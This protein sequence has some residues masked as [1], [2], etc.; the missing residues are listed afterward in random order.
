MLH[1]LQILEQY[2]GHSGFRPNQQKIIEAILENEDCLALLPTGGGKSVCFQIPA[3]IKEGICIVVSPLIALM[4]DQVA[5]LNQKGIKAM[6][7]T[8][9]NHYSELERM[10]DNCVFGN[11]KFLYIS[12]ERLEN[13]L[14][15]DR[16]KS[17]KVSLIAVDEA[18]CIS[19]WGHDFRPAYRN[20]KTLRA[21][22]PHTAVIA[23]TATATKHV[24]KDVTEKLGFLGPKVF[25]SSFFRPN[26]SYHSMS[27]KD[28]QNK[29]ISLLKKVKSS[30]I[31]YV[32][33]RI[34]TEQLATTLELQGISSGFY[35]GGMSFKKKEV[36][37]SDWINNKF[38]VMI[39]TN[40][41]GMGIDKSDVEMVIHLTIPDS[42]EAYFQES[43]RAGR[44]GE[45]SFAYLI[46][47]PDNLLNMKPWF[48]NLIPDVPFLKLIYKKLCTYFQIAY[49][50]FNNERLGLHFDKFCEIY[51]LSK[52]KTYNALKTLESHGV[53]VFE[54]V[55]ENKLTIQFLVSNKTLQSLVEKDNRENNV[56]KAILRSYEGVFAKSTAIDLEK[57]TTKTGL[58]ISAILEVLERLKS[59]NAIAFEKIQTDAQVTFL[60]PREDEKTIHRISKSVSN[61]NKIK[62]KK[63][64]AVLKYVKN[65][66]VCK[67]LQLLTYF[68][69]K[70]PKPCGIC[71]VCTVNSFVN[72]KYSQK[73]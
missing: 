62:L 30:A 53:L 2:W 67:S 29:T 39:A 65:N 73:R 3:L 68:N 58:K 54:K 8:N 59:V 66:S 16:I 37:Y 32:R 63:F 70:P 42:L 26:L 64:H 14:V 28:P 48:E 10:L 23:L 69:E 1:P 43:G 36:M 33:S 5:T 25:K 22:C 55:R 50:E 31:V 27:M 56:T 46:T 12:P 71:N 38:S 34:E 15:Q 72:N 60:V 18:H 35:H 6:A 19:Q 9:V 44:N 13:K 20:I 47:S 41:F 17:M 45:K 11:Y 52:R 57:I 40:A 51:K 21:L 24:I 61:Q 4:Q 7:L 49:G